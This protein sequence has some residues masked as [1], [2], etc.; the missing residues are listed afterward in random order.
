[1]KLKQG[2]TPNKA[3]NVPKTNR[4]KNKMLEMPLLEMSLLD[5]EITIVLFSIYGLLIGS[6][7]NVVAFRLPKG[8]TL[9][10]RSSCPHCK[11]QLKWYHLVPVFSWI[12][13]RGR[14]G[15][16]KNDVSARYPFVEII[17][18]VI[19]LSSILFTDEIIGGLFLAIAVSLL[20]VL[21]IIDYDNMDVPDSINFLSLLFALMYAFTAETSLETSF[22]TAGVLILLIYAVESLTPNHTK[23]MGEGDIIV[24]AT[25]AALVGTLH[26]TFFVFIIACFLMLPISFDIKKGKVVIKRGQVIPF[27]PF[28]FVSFIIVFI[29][30]HFDMPLYQWIKEIYSIS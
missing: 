28:L 23:I 30:K 15:F 29:I 16:C 10:G 8:N 1:L 13:L 11:T 4:R 9:M 27:V 5:K 21:A 6:F 19:F 3:S 26:D 14:C 17:T 20:F 22:I 25:I 24:F 7:L 12:F 18:S 2:N